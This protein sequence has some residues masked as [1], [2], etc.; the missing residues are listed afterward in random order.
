MIGQQPAA[1]AIIDNAQT[2]VQ[3]FRY[4]QVTAQNKTEPAMLE[5]QV[6]FDENVLNDILRSNDLSLWGNERPAVLLWM[7]YDDL[8]GRKLVSFD[9]KPELLETID[10]RAIARGIPLVFPLLDLEDTSRLSVSDVW[11]GF[12]QPVTD[13][14]MR[15]QSD[16]IL[17]TTFNQT[18]SGIWESRWSMF[19]GQESM[20]WVTQGD[21]ADVVLEEGVDELADRLAS[22]YA[23]IGT[24]GAELISLQVTNVNSVDDYARTLSYLESLQSVTSVM[25]K[26]VEKDRVSFELVSHGGLAVL[27]QAIELGKVLRADSSAN[28]LSYTLLSGF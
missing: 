23:N 8:E 2:Y 5:L 12:R 9:E 20:S 3:Q 4:R 22:R 17:V 26:Q 15:Y 1:A 25:V 19:V 6:K 27:N 14:S 13:A 18:A 7:A 11:G 16:V 28:S 10:R 24:S 21:N